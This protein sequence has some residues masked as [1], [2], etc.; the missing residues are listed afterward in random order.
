PERE[1]AATTRQERDRA[2]P[3]SLGKERQRSG[4]ID[5]QARGRR[6]AAR[7]RARAR[8]RGTTGAQPGSPRRIERTSAMM[9]QALVAAGAVCVLSSCAA[10]Q[11]PPEL[12]DARTVYGRVATTSEA[13]KLAPHALDDA[14]IALAAAEEPF[15]KG[16]PEYLVRDRAYIAIRAAELA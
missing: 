15:Q 3:R 16:A 2:R 13:S 1:R 4:R 7:H 5:A 9:N 14:R 11:A 8:G 6:R 10:R 12:V